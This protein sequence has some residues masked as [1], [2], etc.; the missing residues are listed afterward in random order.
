[1]NSITIRPE[2]APRIKIGHPTWLILPIS[3]RFQAR[4][5]WMRRDWSVSDRMLPDALL[6][7]TSR[8]ETALTRVIRLPESPVLN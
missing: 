3:C 5:K 8:W 1:M 7:Y 6:I 4:S 2:V